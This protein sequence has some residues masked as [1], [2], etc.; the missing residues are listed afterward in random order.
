MTAAGTSGLQATSGTKLAP[1]FVLGE[2]RLGQPLWSL[3]I[4]DAYKAEGPKGPAT[5]Y[6]IHA[7]IAANVPVRDQIIAGTRAAAALPE[8]KH[9]VRTLAAGLTGDVLWIAT[10]EVEGQSVRDMLSKKRL[11][12][13][14]A[15]N[16]GLGTRATG[17]LIV[18]ISAALTDV[19]HGALA[20]E[21]VLV[22]RQGRVRVVDLAL[23]PGTVAAM[24]AGLIPG[25][26]S[27]APEVLAS[28]TPSGPGDVFSIG[29]LMYECLVGVPLERG[30]PRPSEVVGGL[31]S[32]IDDLVARACHPD[33]D[34]RFG[35]AEVLGEVIGEALNK[36]GATSAAETAVPAL[37]TAPVP[38]TSLAMEIAAPGADA[39]AAAAV[40]ANVDPALARALADTT[41]KWL[42][43][44]GK[45]DYGPFSLADVLKQIESGEIV[46]GN[47]IM[48]KDTGART[49]VGTHPLLGPMV[50][51][52]RQKRDDARRAQAEVQVAKSDKKRGAM[53][54]AFIGLGVAGAALGAWFII[55]AA[56][57]DEETKK[58]E[59][60]A[61]LD[62]ASLKVTVT[63]PKA[64]PKRANSGGR[65]TGNTGGGNY[66]KGSEDMSLDMSDEDDGGGGTLD[67]GTVYGVYSKQGGKL[68][69]CLQRSGE[70]SANI[71]MIIDG[72]SGRVTFVKVNG[73]QAGAAWAC[74]NGVLRGMQFPTLK[75]GRTRAEFDIGI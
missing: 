20:D 9:L 1:G 54:Y 17:N 66:T 52:A 13:A 63:M 70:G 41:E 30:G 3:R 2:Y 34:K 6:V 31:T 65:R 35:R 55:K 4:A 49:D 50:E 8:H 75:S 56:R 69:G 57:G 29:A 21:S 45:L 25:Q 59:G 58:V 23:G 74:L 11:G 28:G 24:R 72:P 47:L 68:G 62:G 51:V 60:V 64:P 53:L 40:P 73:K 61:A 44:K 71:S 67:M 18:G 48:D 43:S 46:A 37:E 32:Q 5:V 33:A 38:R 36:G 10:E 19:K 26:P 22:N 16:P 14:R 27:V 42:V 39:G 7:N 12:S 15:G